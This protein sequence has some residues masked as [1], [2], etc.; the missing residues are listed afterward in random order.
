VPYEL[1]DEEGSQN[2]QENYNM[3]WKGN[4]YINFSEVNS[5][6]ILRASVTTCAVFGVQRSGDKPANVESNFYE[7]RVLG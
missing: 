6:L 2:W 4:T 1:L 3:K 5:M 7:V